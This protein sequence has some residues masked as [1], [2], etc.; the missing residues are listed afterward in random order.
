MHHLYTLSKSVEGALA[1]AGI[2]VKGQDLV[3]PP[4]DSTLNRRQKIKVVR[5][6]Q[7]R[8]I[9]E[10]EIPYETVRQRDDRLAQ[11]V[12]QVKQQGIKGVKRKVFE[13]VYHDGVEV[14]RELI[15]EEL[16]RKARPQIVSV[17]NRLPLANRSPEES[18]QNADTFTVEATAYTY[19]GRNTATGIAPHRGVIAVDPRVIPLGT[20]LYVEGYG[21]GKALDTGGSIKG[22]RIDVFFNSREEA[23]K[24]GRRSVQ[25][26]IIE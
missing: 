1:Q 5:V 12:E 23:I 20:K 16:I 26:K 4:P 14:A 11:G 21:E 7:E 25:V 17:G 13:R 8:E 18:R 3:E 22:H 6:L 24:W 9:I 10:E 15:E 19:T 2:D